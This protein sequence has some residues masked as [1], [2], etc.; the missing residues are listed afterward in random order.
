ME[1]VSNRQTGIRNGKQNKTM[2]V[3]PIHVTGVA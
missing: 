2:Y 3:Q 1:G